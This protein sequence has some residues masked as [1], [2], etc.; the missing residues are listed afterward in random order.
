MHAYI[1]YIYMLECSPL[2]SA[3]GVSSCLFWK[4]KKA[5]KKFYGFISCFIRSLVA[6]ICPSA[7]YLFCKCASIIIILILS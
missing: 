7:R 1:I 5:F 3:C 2:G 4:K 6:I